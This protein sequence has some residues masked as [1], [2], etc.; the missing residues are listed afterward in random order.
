MKKKYIIGIVSA[1]LILILILLPYL[2]NTSLKGH[3]RG[4]SLYLEK[5]YHDFYGGKE[6]SSFFEKY[7]TTDKYLAIDFYYSDDGRTIF[8]LMKPYTAFIVDI[9][10]EEHEFDQAILELSD[11]E[12][13]PKTINDSFCFVKIDGQENLYKDN[14][15]AIGWDDNHNTIRYVFVCDVKE[16]NVYNIQTTYLR[17]YN[18]NWNDNENDYIFDY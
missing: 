1:L 10:L 5:T 2:W 17:F 15:A 7:I 12:S 8:P 4:S 16:G 18:L 14:F 3:V 11:G 13:D 9:Y 6:A